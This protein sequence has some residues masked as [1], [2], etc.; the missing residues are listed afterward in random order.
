MII[1]LYYK[2]WNHISLSYN[3]HN[4]YKFEFSS[5]I[6]KD[7]V[8]LGITFRSSKRFI[9]FDNRVLYFNDNNIQLRLGTKEERKLFNKEKGLENQKINHQ[10]PDIDFTVSPSDL[11]NVL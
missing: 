10:Y 2:N 5:N 1:N 7:N 6:T 11:F 3:N 8:L 9:R 4:K